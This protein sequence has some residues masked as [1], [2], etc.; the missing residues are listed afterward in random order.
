MPET[1]DFK[2]LHFWPPPS[3]KDDI[4]IIIDITSRDVI[5]IIFYNHSHLPHGL[6]KLA[7]VTMKSKICCQL[8]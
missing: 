2:Q 6:I 8:S 5:R 4:M 7:L 3:L 1:P